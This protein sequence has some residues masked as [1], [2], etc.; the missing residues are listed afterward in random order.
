MSILSAVKEKAAKAAQ[1]AK[2]AAQK[3]AGMAADGVTTL[4]QLSPKQVEEIEAYRQA[5]LKGESESEE[6][7]KDTIARCLQS[8]AIEITQTYLPRLDTLY[9]PVTWIKEA[10]IPQNRIRYYF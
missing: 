8:I 7:E 3:A 2:A 6:K 9:L 5:Y 10:F 1:E 4:S